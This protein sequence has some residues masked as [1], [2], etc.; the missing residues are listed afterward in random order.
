MLSVWKSGHRRCRFLKKI[1]L[2]FQIYGWFL[3]FWRINY[4][5]YSRGQSLPSP[6]SDSLFNFVTH[7]SITLIYS[8]FSQ[9]ILKYSIFLNLPPPTHKQ[10]KTE[11]YTPQSLSLFSLVKSSFGFKHL[12]F[13]L[14]KYS[15][16][17]SSSSQTFC[18]LNPLYS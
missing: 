5:L 9:G 17:Y 16:G 8:S 6:P 15:L 18:S 3:I 7:I 2:Q 1:V 13:L 14:L 10:N 4:S 12:L 11:K